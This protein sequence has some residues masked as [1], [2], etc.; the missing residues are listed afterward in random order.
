MAKVNSQDE[1]EEEFVDQLQVGPG[2]LQ[3]RFIFIRVDRGR[4]LVVCSTMIK[5]V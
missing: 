4:L 3:V 5:N 2:F 1:L